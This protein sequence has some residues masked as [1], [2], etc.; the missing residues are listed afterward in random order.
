MGAAVVREGRL[1]AA[2]RTWPEEAAGRWEL[3]GGKVEPGETP[4]EAL[5]REVAE[6][7]GCSVAVRH[8]L[9]GAQPVAGG[10]HELRVAVVDLV[11]GE[12]ALRE[13]DAVRWLGA[14]DLDD[15]DWLEAD[16]PFLDAVRPLLPPEGG[17]R[18]GPAEAGGP[19]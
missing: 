2:R 18:V 6:E 4:D 9:E 7:M 8:W 5:V 11:A 17:G 1:L 14:A 13:H 16:R 12:P 19:L 10:G 15:L 3:P